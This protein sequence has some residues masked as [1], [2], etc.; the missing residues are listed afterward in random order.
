MQ[1]IAAVVLVLISIMFFWAWREHK[2]SNDTLN[3]LA[4]IF[5]IVAGIAAIILFIIPPPQPT[6]PDENK[7]L[8]S[9]LVDAFEGINGSY[10]NT[11]WN[12]ENECSNDYLL[13][14]NGNLTFQRNH[15]GWTNLSSLSLW[16]YKE[17]SSLEVKIKI[18]NDSN[19]IV[20]W[21]GFNRDASCDIS[22]RDSPSPFIRC[23]FGPDNDRKYISPTIQIDFDTWYI[24]KIAPDYN[25]RII[26]YYLDN[27]LM[28]EYSP[29]VFSDTAQIALGVW[30]SD[31]AKINSVHIDDVRLILKK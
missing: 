23:Y 16:S 26:K 15:E 17:L 3:A 28:G 25:S 31:S 7:Q 4:G 19:F 13:F 21:F 29:S 1:I 22:G 11:L 30:S 8:V 12:C 20:G 6:I 10:D 14:E 24:V 27:V 5:T 2:M 9:G 18:T